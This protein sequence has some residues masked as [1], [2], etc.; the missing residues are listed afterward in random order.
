M[1]ENR[2]I[3]DDE[4]ERLKAEKKE[5]ERKL[6]ELKEPTVTCGRVRFDR[7]LNYAKEYRICISKT[8]DPERF[9]AHRWASIIRSKSKDRVI[10]EIKPLIEDLQDLLKIVGEDE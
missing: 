5:I 4:V 10:S 2:K 1:D 3:I 9:T 8:F 7:E 6:R